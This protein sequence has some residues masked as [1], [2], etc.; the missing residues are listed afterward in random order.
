MR[1]TKT[2]R[3]KG[4]ACGFLRK[5]RKDDRDTP[6]PPL[7]PSELNNA[8]EYLRQ[9]PPPLALRFSLDFAPSF[10]L[11]WDLGDHINELPSSVFGGDTFLAT[12]RALCLYFIYSLKYVIFFIG[13]REVIS[14]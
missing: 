9:Q 2:E 10:G 8:P 12:P 4:K 7:P 11:G 6:P 13:L 1:R 3:R 14:L 5:K